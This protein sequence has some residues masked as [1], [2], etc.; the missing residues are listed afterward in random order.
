MPEAKD[1]ANLE[2]RIEELEKLVDVLYTA[3]Q[4]E[5]AL[6]VDYHVLRFRAS[7]MPRYDVL[8]DNTFITT[9]PEDERAT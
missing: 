8:N 2:Q 6:R 7:K 1:T 3:C 4:A 5:P 9:A